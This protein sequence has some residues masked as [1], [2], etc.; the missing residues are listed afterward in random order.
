[1]AAGRPADRSV[2]KRFLG[3]VAAAVIWLVALELLLYGLWPRIDDNDPPPT[4]EQQLS[5]AAAILL[6]ALPH[7]VAL[8]GYRGRPALFKVAGAIGI[9]LTIAAGVSFFLMILS[10]PLLLIPSIVYLSRSTR[11]GGAT[12][13]STKRLVG[14]ALL[15]VVA[16]VGVLFLTRDPRCT[17]IIERQGEAVY[18]EPARCDPNGTATLGPRVTEWSGSSDAIAWHESLISLLLSGSVVVLCL[19]GAGRETRS[20]EEMSR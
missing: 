6:F 10:V 12:R 20:L 2:P 8:L 1:M 7:L 16:A 19:W 3:W 4:I 15:L 17:I 5:L 18:D 9:A 11:I 14:V 13:I